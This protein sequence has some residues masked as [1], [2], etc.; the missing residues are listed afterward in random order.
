MTSIIL[1]QKVCQVVL[2]TLMGPNFL[3]LQFSRNLEV[4][5]MTLFILKGAS[6]TSKKGKEIISVGAIFSKEKMNS[7]ERIHAGA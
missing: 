4:T 5:T 7:V 1:V 2:N 6:C 3:H